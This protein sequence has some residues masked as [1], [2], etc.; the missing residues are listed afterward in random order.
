[1]GDLNEN[2]L[3]VVWNYYQTLPD[4]DFRKAIL[5]E[6]MDRKIQTILSKY[7]KYNFKML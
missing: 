4:S 2:N 7:E 6:I 5:K 1:M 3:A